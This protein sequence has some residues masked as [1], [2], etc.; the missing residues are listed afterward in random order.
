MQKSL[1]HFD[2]PISCFKSKPLATDSPFHNE[3]S[4]VKISPFNICNHLLKHQEKIFKLITFYVRSSYWLVGQEG[5][6]I[7]LLL[8]RGYQRG[9]IKGHDI[10]AC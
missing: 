10:I 9:E 7:S 8:G 3:I 6:H 1:N 5:G 2:Q 4:V